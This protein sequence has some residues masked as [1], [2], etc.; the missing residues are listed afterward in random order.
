VK[1]RKLALACLVAL[2][3]AA[4]SAQ[5]GVLPTKDFTVT[6]TH[7]SRFSVGDVWEYHTRE[8]E[9]HSRVTIVR[10]DAS[11]ELGMIVHIAVEGIRLT[12]CNNGPE[13]NNVPHMPFS[14]KAFESSVTKKIDSGHALPSG[15]KDGYGEWKSAYSAG[16]A[17]IY[18]IS[19][20]EAVGVAEKTF[21]RGNGCDGASTTVSVK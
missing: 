13:P 6:E 14:R 17:G 20:A 18:L 16:K 21:Q 4:A 3:A 7:D 2:T 12:N 19:I 10:L 5:I 15:W 8:G 9:E 11:P 1:L